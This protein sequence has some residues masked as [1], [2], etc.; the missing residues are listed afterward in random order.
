M[1]VEGVV[2]HPKK[3]RRLTIRE[4]ATIKSLLSKRTDK[5]LA[6]QFGVG[7]GTIWHIRNG[8][9]HKW[10]TAEMAGVMNGRS[11]Y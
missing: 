3:S 5:Q 2:D 7:I 9:T 8:L 1:Q 11:S 4:V 10:V 6:K